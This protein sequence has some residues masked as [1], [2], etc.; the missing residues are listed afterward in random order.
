[1]RAD[2][3]HQAEQVVPAFEHTDETPPGVFAGDVHHDRSQFRV[4]LSREGQ[5]PDRVL[6]QRVEPG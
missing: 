2:R 4:I 6:R 5:P 1:M 3:G